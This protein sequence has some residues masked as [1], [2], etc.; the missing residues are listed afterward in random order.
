MWRIVNSQHIENCEIQIMKNAIFERTTKPAEA[1]FR[2]FL[3]RDKEAKL[4]AR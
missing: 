4:V 2:N 3:R 1:T